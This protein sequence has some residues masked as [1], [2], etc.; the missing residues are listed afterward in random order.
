MKEAGANNQSLLALEKVIKAIINKQKHIPY[1][2]SKLTLILKDSIGGNSKT[3]IIATISHLKDNFFQTINTLEFVQ[4]AKKI[5]NKAI[6]NEEYIIKEENKKIEQLQKINTSL[7]EKCEQLEINQRISMNEKEGLLKIIKNQKEEIEKMINDMLEKENE[8]TKFKEENIKLQDNIEKKDINIQII[9]HELNNLKD[10]N[11]ELKD[12]IENLNEEIKKSNENIEKMKIKHQKQ[13][14]NINEKNKKL[15]KNSENDS[16]I[17]ELEK[18][19]EMYKKELNEKKKELTELNNELSVYKDK[20]F[21]S[22]QIKIIKKK[23]KQITELKRLNDQFNQKIQSSQ[24]FTNNYLDQINSL[25]QKNNKLKQKLNSIRNNLLNLLDSSFFNQN[26]SS[27]SIGQFRVIY[28]NTLDTI[29]ILNNVVNSKIESK[30]YSN[31]ITGKMEKMIDDHLN[32]LL[33]KLNTSNI[34]NTQLYNNVQSLYSLGNEIINKKIEK[35]K[36][37]YDEL[38]SLYNSV[39]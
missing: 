11:E 29:S 19:N 5:K 10:E 23:D 21:I 13:I 36:N 2:E 22:N 37:I 38:K 27:F 31:T 16:L 30:K 32:N 4:N 12:K 25:T 14:S 17:E 6:I 33:N 20:K 15:K 9:A 28:N 3:S 34:G 8:L 24:D 35:I 26:D 1:R 18:K 7:I 39:K